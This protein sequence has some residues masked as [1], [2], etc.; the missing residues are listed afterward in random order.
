MWARSRPWPGRARNGRQARLPS[1]PPLSTASRRDR[2]WCAWQRQRRA[3]AT[4]GR[5]YGQRRNARPKTGWA[6]SVNRADDVSARPAVAAATGEAGRHTPGVLT[7]T[8][9]D[10]AFDLIRRPPEPERPPEPLPDAD[11]AGPDVRGHLQDRVLRAG[12]QGVGEPRP[13]RSLSAGVGQAGRFPGG[14]N[15]CARRPNLGCRELPFARLSRRPEAASTRSRRLEV[16][17]E[18]APADLFSRRTTTTCQLLA[19]V[20]HVAL[21]A[22][23]MLKFKK[24]TG[25]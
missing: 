18:G 9:A 2:P 17:A 3:G 23:G 19:E 13:E 10:L 8:T 1:R 24:R 14:P 22:W 15:T 11:H 6:A 25:C 5:E 12:L 4:R 7:E 20:A 21:P 16:V